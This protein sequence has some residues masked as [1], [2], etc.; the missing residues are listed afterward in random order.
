LAFN[1][2]TSDQNLTL[3]ENAAF[4]LGQNSLTTASGNATTMMAPEGV[5]SDGTSLVVGDTNANRVLVW[6]TVPSAYTAPNFA[7]GQEG[8]ASVSVNKAAGFPDASS[9][10][11]P[12]GVAFVGG[13]IHIADT[14]N[15]R[16]FVVDG[17]PTAHNSPAGLLIGQT[18]ASHAVS[19]SPALIDGAQISPL[20]LYA[21]ANRLIVADGPR[22]R[23]L[24]WNSFPTS[25]NVTPDLVLGQPI[26]FQM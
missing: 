15:N 20:R 3:A 19:N 13:K 18:A 8:F 5:A 22:N 24:I 2:P 9:L 1:L 23:V 12:R 26:Y 7:I 16:I 4:V 10:F 6:T 25:N 11:K 14:S 21:D 17:T